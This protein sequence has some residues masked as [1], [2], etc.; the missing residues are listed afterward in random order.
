VVVAL[1]FGFSTPVKHIGIIPKKKQSNCLN[2]KQESKG[3]WIKLT[4]VRS[5]YKLINMEYKIVYAVAP[6]YLNN[7]VNNLIKEGWKPIGGH[8]V[9]VKHIQ[10]RF[11][12][13]Q[14]KDTINEL[15]Y[16]QTMIKEDVAPPKS[17]TIV[18]KVID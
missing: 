17:E 13:N 3:K 11:S 10:N 7:E 18:D 14:H 4:F 9:V 6:S 1:S 12:G 5:F 15:E 8:Q 2:K 16:T